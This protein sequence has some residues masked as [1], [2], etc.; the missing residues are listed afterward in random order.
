MQTLER[1]A[2]DSIDVGC[3]IIVPLRVTPLTLIGSYTYSQCS[4]RRLDDKQW[5]NTAI[6]VTTSGAWVFQGRSGRFVLH[7]GDVSVG[8]KNERFGC[9]HLPESPNTNL[10]LG[11]CADAVDEDVPVMFERDVLH[12]PEII[13]MIDRAIRC[14]DTGLRDTLVFGIF[15]F[16][17]SA[18]LTIKDRRSAGSLRVQ[19]LKRFIEENAFE[20]IRL[21]DMAAVV[22]L[23]P[24]VAI[25]QFKKHVGVTPYTYLSERRTREA[26]RLLRE[27]RLAIE[28]VANRT[29]FRDPAYF[30]R[31]FRRI[32]GVSPSDFRAHATS[33]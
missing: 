20:D 32:T 25:R 19:R 2:D 27:T 3:G 1:T 22:G 26:Q 4:K 14:E 23:S 6:N 16:V 17:R 29:G 21:R 5:P 18:S 30:S 8:A 9:A 15:D 11:L 10:I 28:E 7:A 13:P 31:F 24:Y 33:A 12:I